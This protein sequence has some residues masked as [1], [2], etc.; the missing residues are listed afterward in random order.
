MTSSTIDD[1]AWRRM[2]FVRLVIPLIAGILIAIYLEVGWI[3][4]LVLAILGSSVVLQSTHQGHSLA[5]S[6]RAMGLSWNHPLVVGNR[7]HLGRPSD[8]T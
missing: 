7:L 5:N 8:H 1:Y 4:G 6:D 2:P 3:A